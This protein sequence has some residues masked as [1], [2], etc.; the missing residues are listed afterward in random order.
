MTRQEIEQEIKADFDHMLSGYGYDFQSVVSCDPTMATDD[1]EITATVKITCE[2]H[3]KWLFV[4][5][6]RIK[7]KLAEIEISD[8]VWEIASAS[9]MWRMLFLDA[10][11]YF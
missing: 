10:M 8:D 6:A 3:P 2:H 5:D 11:E 9:T 1:P 4:V 7:D